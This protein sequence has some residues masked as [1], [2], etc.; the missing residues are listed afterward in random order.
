MRRIDELKEIIQQ[1]K[2]KVIVFA[3]FVA[4]VENLSKQIPGSMFIHGGV[5]KTERDRILKNFQTRTHSGKVLVAQPGTMSRGLTL[6]QANTIVWYGGIY[7]N[8]TYLQANRRIYRSGQVRTCVVVH[9]TSS[10]FETK[11]YNRLKNKQKLQGLVLDAVHER[12][13]K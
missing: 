7:S 9:L 12:V 6:V 1:S 2:G 3:P 10:E 13:R 5:G 11:L 4:V 8:E